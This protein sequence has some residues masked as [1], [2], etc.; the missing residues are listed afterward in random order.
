M[1][2]TSKNIGVVVDELMIRYPDLQ[3]VYW[4]IIEEAIYR[5]VEDNGGAFATIDDL[6]NH[7]FENYI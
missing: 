3:T 2:I 5:S 7:I 1:K 6:A 4:D